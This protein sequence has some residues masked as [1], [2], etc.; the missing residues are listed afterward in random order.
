MRPD[1]VQMLLPLALAFIM[2][3]LGLTLVVADFRQVARR[4]K[5]LGVGLVAQVLLVPLAGLAV[6][7]FS[8]LIH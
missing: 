7:Q 6:A 1:V 2:F 8:G 5:A 4:P 3:Y